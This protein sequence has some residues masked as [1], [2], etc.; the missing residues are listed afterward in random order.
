MAKK[1]KE[2]EVS[3]ETQIQQE[4]ANICTSIGDKEFLIR[5]TKGEVVGLFAQI[6]KLRGDL[7]ALA[8]AAN[9]SEVAK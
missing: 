9:G 5:R 4:I 2:A 3:K 7:T 1:K 6:D 8:G